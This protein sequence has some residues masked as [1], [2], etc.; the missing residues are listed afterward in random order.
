MVTKRSAIVSISAL[1]VS[2]A[3]AGCH[4]DTPPPPRVPVPL[5]AS[6]R[7][8]DSRRVSARE[9]DERPLPPD[10]MRDARDEDDRIA[11]RPPADPDRDPIKPLPPQGHE[12][13]F[14]P[15]F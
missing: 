6:A 12:D 2:A 15:P 4:D 3:I 11:H 10:A 7:D 5:P 1:V 8:A 13:E 9:R 14:Q